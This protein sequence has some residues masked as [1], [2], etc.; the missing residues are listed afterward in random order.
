MNNLVFNTLTI[1]VLAILI[2]STLIG[3]QKG[4]IRTILS[5]FSI[6]ISLVLAWIIYPHVSGVLGEFRDLHQ[7]VYE[8]VNEFFAEQIPELINGVMESAGSEEQTSL[9]DQ[10]PLPQLIKD[11]LAL[12][13]TTA[14]YEALGVKNF[15][16][17]LSVTVTKL[18]IQ[19][20]SLLL[21]LLISIIGLH[22]LMIVTDLVAKLPVIN[23]L[24]R[25]GGAIAGL[26]T[27]YLIMQ[28]VFLAITTFS[29]TQWGIKL[30]QQIN[31][32]Q[33]LTFLY[34]SSAMIKMIF[35]ELTSHLQALVNGLEG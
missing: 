20:I 32:S 9:I 18:I 22:L 17:Y 7:F 10:L 29:G 11:T 19:A 5:L 3:M 14:A 4:L 13:N 26:A 24:N 31:E 35:T 21:T 34:N 2:F 27:G 6:V 1:I 33:I 16:E 23:S 25:L 8:P 30:M 28:I 15:V 12:N